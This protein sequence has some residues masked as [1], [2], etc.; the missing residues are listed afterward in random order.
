ML[1]E[2]TEIEHMVQNRK[3]GIIQTR[4]VDGL[5]AWATDGIDFRKFLVGMLP[6]YL[7]LK[8]I[9]FCGNELDT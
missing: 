5:V 4:L 8:Q 7:L 2:E 3:I 9:Y 6:S 1:V